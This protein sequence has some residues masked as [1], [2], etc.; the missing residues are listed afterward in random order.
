MR[1]ESYFSLFFWRMLKQPALNSSDLHFSVIKCNCWTYDDNIGPKLK[2]SRGLLCRGVKYV[3]KSFNIF[4]P[5]IGY[6]LKDIQAEDLRAGAFSICHFPFLLH[7]Y[8]EEN[9]S[10]SVTGTQQARERREIL[11]IILSQNAP[12]LLNSHCKNCKLL[13]YYFIC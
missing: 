10:N 3:Q 13:R 8:V 1:F 2:K 11:S 5:P 4:T 9:K 7:F 12:L 6:I